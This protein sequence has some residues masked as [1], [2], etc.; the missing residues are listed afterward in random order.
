MKQ[1]TAFLESEGNAYWERNAATAASWR[2]PEDDS[3]LIAL[4]EIPGL[5]DNSAVLEIGCGEGSRLSWLQEHRGIS[6]Y[7]VEPSAWAVGM[8]RDRN[9]DVRQGTADRLPFDDGMFDVVIFGWCLYLC[10][11]EDLFRIA[12]EAD[13]VLRNP[14]WLLIL[15]YFNPAAT[16][17]EYH[18]RPGVFSYKMDYRKLFTWNPGY[19]EYYQKTVHFVDRNYTDDRDAWASTTVLRK[20]MAANQFPV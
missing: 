19:T 8:A 13:R 6:C 2:L 5:G 12:Y 7:G 15:D 11:R 16:K 10:D 20:N 14:G 3:V 17:R 9:V 18:H 1:K 4:L